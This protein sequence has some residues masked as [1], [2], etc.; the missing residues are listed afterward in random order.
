MEANVY[1]IMTRISRELIGLSCVLL[2]ATPA[3]AVP[4]A[5][6]SPPGQIDRA[7]SA[8]YRIG[9][10][11]LLEVDV[12][13]LD[14]LDST[15]RVSEDGTIQLPLINELRIAGMTR[16][17]AAEAIEAAL[18]RYVKEPEV[19]IEVREFQSQRYTVMGAVNSPGIYTI[20]GSTRLLEALSMA[21]GLNVTEAEGAI[22]IVRQGLGG[23]PIVIDAGDLMDRGDAAFNITLED[24]DVVRVERKPRYKI[25]IHGQVAQP[26]E[27]ELREPITL[28]RAIVLAGGLGDRAAAGRIRILRTTQDGRQEKAEVN[29]EKIEDGDAEDVPLLPNDVIIVPETVF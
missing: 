6:Q 13:G 4:S 10:D 14:D 26:G 21:G 9:P 24:G 20:E 25:Y 19:L 27:Y 11:D 5:P 28:L 2:V 18:R 15:V 22:S 16:S 1:E 12:V 17:E 29:F 23:A 3:L 7:P 8:R